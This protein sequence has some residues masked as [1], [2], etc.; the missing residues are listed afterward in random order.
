VPTDLQTTKLKFCV[1]AED[2]AGNQRTSC[3]PIRFG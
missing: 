2:P 1:L 3:A